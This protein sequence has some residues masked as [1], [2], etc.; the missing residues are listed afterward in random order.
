MFS[1]ISNPFASLLLVRIIL[2]QAGCFSDTC[3]YDYESCKFYRSSLSLP[4][5]S[6]PQS[7]ASICQNNNLNFLCI[8]E[9]LGS[10]NIL[11]F[12]NNPMDFS[13]IQLHIPNFEFGNLSRCEIV[14]GFYYYPKRKS[15]TKAAPE[16]DKL[17]LVIKLDRFLW[18][19]G[20]KTFLFNNILLDLGL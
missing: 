16:W 18:C 12:A 6:V 19:L 2:S 13:L 15:T 4:N 17:K 8:I 3:G 14:S 7:V 10:T 9:L 1:F 11:L 5:A 20:T